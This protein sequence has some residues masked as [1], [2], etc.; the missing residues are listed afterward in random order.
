MMK[1]DRS[2]AIKV[3]AALLVIFSI[4]VALRLVPWHNF[5]TPN[6][7]YFLESDNY[8]HL[9]KISI[10]LHNLLHVP[11]R[12]YY[13]GYPVGT[14]SI[15]SPLFDLGFAA[16]IKLLS[17]P[18]S[19]ERTALL[20]AALPPFIGMLAVVPLFFWVRSCFG[21]ATALVS[22]AIFAL[23]PGHLSVTTVGRPDNELIEPICAA[24]L[25]FAY[26]AGCTDESGEGTGL[27]RA[28]AIGVGTGAVATLSLLFWR[29]A[30]LWWAIL[31][32]HAF[33]T[34]VYRMLRNRPLSAAFWL[35]SVTAFA[36]A[37]VLVS[38]VSLV[39]P[40]GLPGGMHF[41][42]VSWFHAVTALIAVAALAGAGL[43]AYLRQK[44]G[45]SLIASIALGLGLFALL[46]ALTA[47]VA[48]GYF[49][50]IFQGASIV[51]GGNKWTQTIEQY[52][53]LFQDNEGRFSVTAP[54][55]TLTL[56]LFI[57]PLVL[58]CLTFAKKG[59]RAAF[60]AFAGWLIL[61]LTLTNGRYETALTLVV[62]AC[63]ALLASFIY[64]RASA[65]GAIAGA[66]ASIIVLLILFS[67]AFAYYGRLSR[68]S[69]FLIKGD[70][71]KS[72]RWIRDNTPETSYY[73]APSS[74]PEYA[75]M[76]R[77]EF[78]GWISEIAKRPTVAT[79]YGIEAHGMKESAGFFLA[80]DNKEFLDILDGN[81]ARYF[82][83]SKTIG[84]LADYAKLL[85][86]ES[87]GYLN[88]KVDASGRIVLE[89]GPRYFDL[90][91][92]NLYLADGEASAGPIPFPGV[93]GA[94]LVYESPSRAQVGGVGREI[95]QFKVFERVKGAVVVG[96]A[97]PGERVTLAG[98]V[99][100][101][102]NRRFISGRAAIAGPDG[103]FSIKAW[104]PSTDPSRHGHGVGVEGGYTLKTGSVERR[105]P[106]TR[107]DVIEGRVI[108]VR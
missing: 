16:L 35:F 9:R 14:G 20:C 43:A 40:W 47:A 27:Y 59:A 104:Y 81:G 88:E 28:V 18:V 29:G 31:G 7:V 103:S 24:L 23:L 55:G 86:R 33:L 75:V 102:Q 94:R 19:P 85:G 52:K 67:P 30:I 21:N 64:R 32:A 42:I 15:S 93:D 74:K 58:A 105:L 2:G 26:S 63:G 37:A 82:I 48:P 44:R 39:K 107:E 77:W 50:G 83:L 89:T 53:P 80:S 99:I 25:F 5:I 108:T 34:I 46:G 84:A 36:S 13:A 92:V 61:A 45:A 87:E 76:A 66:A 41:N 98:V 62:S 78:S 1:S 10:L 100:T 79:G 96:K 49:K 12:D 95:K 101:N 68:Q 91:Y 106:V 8:D 56:L 72:L 4:G 11:V 60:F 70:L 97:A 51:G 90:A 38:I 69:P 65:K 54:L 3:F 6:G 22:C 73:L 17:W 71:E 57:T